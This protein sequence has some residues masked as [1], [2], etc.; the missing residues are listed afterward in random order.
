MS[1]KNTR[2]WFEMM[3]LVLLAF[4]WG[5]SYLLIKIAVSEIPPITLV[6]A[7]VSLALVFILVVMFWQGL[8]FPTDWKTWQMLFIQAIFNSI[9]AWTVLAWGQQHIDSGLAS[10][11]NSTAPIFIFFIT[12]FFT[13]HESVS[14]VKLGGA[15]LGIFG[16]I[17]I[18]GVD[19]LNDFGTQVAGML[20][21]LTGA[22]LY[23]FAAIYGRKFTHLNAIVTAAGTLI[24]AT[25]CLIP[26]SLILEKPWTLQPSTDAMLATLSLAIFCTG[27]ALLIYFRLLKTIGSM[28]VASQAY[29]RA[30]IG[31]MLGM[32]FLN[33]QISLLIGLG[34]AMAV[35]GVIA[36]NMP[37]RAV[38]E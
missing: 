28:G 6:A 16:V 13:R 21:A 23:A 27:G 8:R 2:F 38:N 26:F 30:G 37:V 33:E 9:G 29:L 5:S 12:L 11:L 7:R 17:L 14:L 36:I 31:V 35:L 15:L 10:V 18:V 32:V 24:W 34:L 3:L 4:L 1:A 20:A 19:A 25:V 22:L